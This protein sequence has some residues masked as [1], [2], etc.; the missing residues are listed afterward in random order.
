MRPTAVILAKNPYRKWNDYD[1]LLMRAY[2]Q[3]KLEDCPHCNLPR[4]L[5]NNDSSDIRFKIEKFDCK[6]TQAI[7]KRRK[8]DYPNGD[9]PSDIQYIASPYSTEGRPLVDYRYEYY[10]DQVVQR[11]KLAALEEV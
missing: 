1:H 10:K 7:E 5:C 6:A 9:V 2:K 8:L 11:E 4:Y 3:A